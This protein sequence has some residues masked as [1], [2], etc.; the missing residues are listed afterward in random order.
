[1]PCCSTAPGI[2]CELRFAGSRPLTLCEGDGTTC[3]LLH[4]PLG[5]PRALASLVRAP[6]DSRKGHEVGFTTGRT[7]ALLR[8]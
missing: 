7:W 1:M 6:F 8:G 4:H 5:I 3:S 2:P